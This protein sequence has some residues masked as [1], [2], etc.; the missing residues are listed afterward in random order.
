MRDVATRIADRLRGHGHEVTVSAVDAATSVDG[1]DAVVLGSVV[2]DGAWTDDAALDR[3]PPERRA[4]DVDR[5]RPTILTPPA[6]S[7]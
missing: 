5:A 4:R 7:E 6:S 2:Y 1:Y 3:E